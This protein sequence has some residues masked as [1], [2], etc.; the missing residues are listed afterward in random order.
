R[1][2][3][4]PS[5]R[6]T[7]HQGR[8]QLQPIRHRVYSL[9]SKTPNQRRK[10]PEKKGER[11][12]HDR[13]KNAVSQLYVQRR[14]TSGP[15]SENDAGRSE[16]H[17]QPSIS[18]TGYGRNHGARG[19]GGTSAVQLCSC[20]RHQG[21]NGK[22]GSG[23]NWAMTRTTINSRHPHK[24]EQAAVSAEPIKAADGG[25][26]PSKRDLVRGVW[27]GVKADGR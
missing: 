7:N 22:A 12:R 15:G 20:D 3:I 26:T 16:N 1:N 5:R 2:L 13:R 24:T 18:R 23:R 14:E 6:R 9:R 10:L 4:R 8:Q 27:R 11:P 21:I 17:L 25:L 19:F